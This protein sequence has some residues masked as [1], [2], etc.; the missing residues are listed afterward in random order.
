MD[1]AQLHP[2]CPISQL[3]LNKT[4]TELS[5]TESGRFSKQGWQHN[6]EAN[7][8]VQELTFQTWYT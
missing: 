7:F 2:V 3:T 1:P 5:G 4:D 6:K 8:G